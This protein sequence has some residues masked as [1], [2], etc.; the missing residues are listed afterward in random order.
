MIFM[1]IPL[2]FQPHRVLLPGEGRNA[3][4]QSL[5]FFV[6]PDNEVMVECVDGSNKYPAV[7]AAQDTIRRL[8][9]TY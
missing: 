2:P 9:R 1:V 6:H 5:A 7:T 4:R 3:V 8:D